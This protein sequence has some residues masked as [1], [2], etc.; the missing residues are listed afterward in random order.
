MLELE[1]KVKEFSE[2]ESAW[3]KEKDGY[4][5]EIARLKKQL[6]EKLTKEELETLKRDLGDDG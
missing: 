5:K 3:K 4:E 1:A 2:K 6:Q